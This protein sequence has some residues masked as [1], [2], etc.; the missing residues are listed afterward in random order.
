MACCPCSNATHD[1]LLHCYASITGSVSWGGDV[2]LTKSNQRQQQ[3]RLCLCHRVVETTSAHQN[4]HL[5]PSILFVDCFSVFPVSVRKG[6]WRIKCQARGSFLQSHCSCRRL[7]RLELSVNV[8]KCCPDYTESVSKS[9]HKCAVN[10]APSQHGCRWGRCAFHSNRPL[11]VLFTFLCWLQNAVVA[12]NLR[13][14][15]TSTV[16][17]LRRYKTL[18]S[19]A[20]SPGIHQIHQRA[21]KL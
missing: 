12:A 21:S 14:F 20:K 8:P 2:A 10:V 5:W 16:A 17:L 1:A 9:R 4:A 19:V 15:H 7:R 11:S 13:S 3:V 18:T 6:K